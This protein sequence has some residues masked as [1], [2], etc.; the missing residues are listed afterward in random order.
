M[1][2]NIINS[3][4]FFTKFTNLFNIL[5]LLSKT[6]RVPRHVQISYLSFRFIFFFKFINL[7]VALG[8]FF[9]ARLSNGFEKSI[10]VKSKFFF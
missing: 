10:P 4:F 7:N 9:L 6:L 8:T 5:N 2:S 3:P 1:G